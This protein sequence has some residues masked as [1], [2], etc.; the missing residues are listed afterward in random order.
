MAYIVI[1]TQWTLFKNTLHSL[2]SQT[3]YPPPPKK[4]IPLRKINPFFLMHT[5]L[6]HG[7]RTNRGIKISKIT[8][9]HVL[10]LWIASKSENEPKTFGSII[11]LTCSLLFLWGGVLNCV[12]R[13]LIKL[14]YWARKWYIM[15]RNSRRCFNVDTAYSIRSAYPLFKISCMY[16]IVYGPSDTF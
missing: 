13:L 15:Y 14:N 7:T 9:I 8:T 5:K 3:T 2:C 1:I 12:S 4:K 10:H 6:V 16:I 11:V